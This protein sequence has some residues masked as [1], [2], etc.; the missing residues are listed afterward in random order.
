MRATYFGNCR[1]IIDCDKLI[2]TLDSQKGVYRNANTPYGDPS[3]FEDPV[4]GPEIKKMGDT[5]KH[6]GYL[7]NNSVEYIN[8]YPDQHF[9]T[10]YVD[11]LS[12]LFN[13]KPCRIWVSSMRTGKCVPWHWD[14]EKSESDYA[15]QGTIVRYSIFV[16]TPQIGQV[17]VL[18]DQCFH[19][20]DQGSIY[21][22]S[23]WKDYHLGFNCGLDTKYLLHYIGTE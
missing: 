9:S 11:K 18:N 1:N 22:W 10:D 5:W 4:L 23:N 20:I 21:K 7:D 12:N 6:A 8:Y 15:K 19:M 2:N 16:D 13:A 3:I 14:V 17:F